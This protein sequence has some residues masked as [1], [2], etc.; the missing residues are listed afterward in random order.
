MHNEIAPYIQ[1]KRKCTEAP[2]DVDLNLYEEE[3]QYSREIDTL[4]VVAKSQSSKLGIEQKI[5]NWTGFNYLICGD[6]WDNFHNIGYL[7]A[8]NQSPTSHDTVLELLSQSKV[9]AEKL[10]L[11]ET[12][13]VLD[14]GIYAKA[15]EIIMNPRYVDL[16]RSSLCWV[17][18]LSTPCAFLL[19]L[20]ENDLA[21]LA[22]AI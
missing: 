19:P 8:I 9:K 3:V 18:E 13:V 1:V 21:M 7:P 15:V 14:M 2:T 6:D 12:D 20:L 10:E 16:I 5:P 22:F 4:W 17:L 11:T